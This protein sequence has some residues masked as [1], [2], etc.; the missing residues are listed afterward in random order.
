MLPKIT[1]WRWLSSGKRTTEIV[2]ALIPKN[3]RRE[4]MLTYCCT[5]VWSLFLQLNVFFFISGWQSPA[6]R[7]RPCARVWLVAGL[8]SRCIAVWWRACAE[9]LYP[10]NSRPGNCYFGESPPTTV[11]FTRHIRAIKLSFLHYQVVARRVFVA[12]RLGTTVLLHHTAANVVFVTLLL[13]P[14]NSQIKSLGK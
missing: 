4:M 10:V 6:L 5:I 13:L 3:A 1:R 12:R 2:S 8:V 11:R 9:E 7:L 14:C